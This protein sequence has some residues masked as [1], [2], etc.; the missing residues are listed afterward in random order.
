MR[1][2]LNNDEVFI[3]SIDSL[4]SIEE[5][6]EKGSQKTTSNVL[7]IGTTSISELEDKVKAFRT[8]NLNVKKRRFIVSREDLN[9]SNGNPI[10]K[11]GEDI[12]ISKVKLLRRTM[13][14]ETQIKTFQ[15]DEGIVLITD[16]S[17]PAGIQLS[18]NMV[19]QI[20]NIGGG[21]YEAF[22]D[23]VDSFKELSTLL[24]KALFPKMVIVG[25]IPEEKRQ[26]ELI[27][28]HMVKKID[29]YIR[30]IE[31]NHTTIKPKAFIPK[32]RQILISPEDSDSW[33]RFILEIISEYTKP[34]SIEDR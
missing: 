22:I 8:I 21:A 32:L 18:M 30:M 11:R 1:P 15:P 28:Y 10:V 29:A 27:Y 19:T 26:E 23:R 3:Y 24:T 6:S 20:M 4:N 2:G 5:L 7:K 25:F 16:M 34:Y 12:D 13:K 31:I 9:N 17:S 14:A 33:K